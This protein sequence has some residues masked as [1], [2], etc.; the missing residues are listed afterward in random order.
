MNNETSPVFKT[1]LIEFVKS[2]NEYAGKVLDFANHLDEAATIAQSLPADIQLE[3]K[4]II[5]GA[6][7]ANGITLPFNR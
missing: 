2:H 5:L 6:L 7:A 1:V 4:K 3:L